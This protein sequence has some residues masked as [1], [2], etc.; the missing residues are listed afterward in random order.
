[1]RFPRS[2]GLLLHPTSLPGAFGIGGMGE[3][4]R[5]FVD[6]LVQAGQSFWQILPLG[7]T[8]YG[9]SPYACFSAF[10]GNPY[11]IDLARLAAEGDLDTGDPP[12]FPAD[13]VDFG[14]VFAHRADVLPRAA[15]RFRERADGER[16]EAFDRFCSENADWLDD[17]ALFRALKDAHG[18]A[19]WA[20]W[21]LAAREPDALAE[22]REEL[23][24]A[25]FARQYAQYQFHRQ[26]DELKAYA[27]ERGVRIVGDIPIFVACDS[28][29]VWANPGLFQLDE[30]LKSIAVAGVPPD[31]FSKTGQL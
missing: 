16:R 15:A 8:G 23:A 31:Y 29:D 24:D 12:A 14:A 2:A 6:F 25:V 28:A 21:P 3:S 9:D 26:W 18:G 11:L 17:Y 1:M 27:N 5:Q 19:V 22:A 13:R 10:A 30:R 4:A 20:T 7:P